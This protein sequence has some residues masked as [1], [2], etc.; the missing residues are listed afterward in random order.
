MSKIIRI[1]IDARYWRGS[2]QTGIERYLHLL[3]EA[4]AA[5]GR[6]DLSVGVVLK[7]HEAAAFRSTY[8][9]QLHLTTLTVPDRRQ[10]SLDRVLA[11][12]AP[13]VVHFPF[14]LPA[15]LTYPSVFTLHDAGRYLFPDQMVREV[16]E[17]QNDR[18]LRHLAGP[19]LHAVITVSEAA[20]DDIVTAL[21]DLPRPLEV[22][23]N[24][25]SEGF[26]EL[27]RETAPDPVN[28][29]PFLF[30]VG[31][32]MPTKNVPRLCRAYRM[33]R[34]MAGDLVPARLLLAG[35]RGW[36][37]SLPSQKDP[38]IK[39][40]GHV[41][42]EHLAWLYRNTEAFIFPP[43]FEGFGIPAQEALQAGCRLLC[44]DIPP[45]REVTGGL[46]I[47]VDPHDDASL[48]KGIIE[49]C[50]TAAPR[51]QDVRNA[52]ADYSAVVIGPQ[53]LDV[54]RRAAVAATD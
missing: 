11:R 7:E 13:Q 22:V 21:G 36:E 45:L 16:R 37:R 35:R 32:Y 8:Q 49:T 17:V 9:E 23:P 19:N 28:D 4:L 20:R 52:L 51:P 39:V 46:G 10:I 18:L 1:A 2:I 26:T 14:E 42:D 31:V 43:L 24:F 47:F 50:T 44:S 27:L 3:L 25:V 6:D 30:G 15:H 54:Y 29:T 41:D 48:A 34:E 12:F 40:L 33:A 53:L 38:S 5:T